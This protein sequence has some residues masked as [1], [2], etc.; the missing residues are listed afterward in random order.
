MKNIVKLNWLLGV[1]LYAIA[2]FAMWS[3]DNSEDGAVPVLDRVSLVPKDSTTEEGFRG[4]TYVIFGNNLATTKAVYFNG[5]LAPL[6]TTYVRNDNIIVRIGDKT[7]YVNAIN[8][9]RVV[10]QYGEAAMDFVVKQKPVIDGFSPAVA[11]A[12][13]IVTIT[14]NCFLGLESVVFVDA[15]TSVETEAEIV[16]STVEEIQV[17]VPEGTKVSYIKVTTPGGTVRSSSTFGFNYVIYADQLNPAW[18]NWSWSSEFNYNST[19]QVKS[20]QYSYKQTYTGGWGGIQLYGA[21]LPL[22][23]G[24]TFLYEALKMSIYGGPGTEGKEIILTINWSVQIRITLAEGK[25]KDFTIPLSDLG[26]P[27]KINVLVMQ[28]VG[29]V[30]VTAPYLMYIDDM[31]LI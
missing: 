8:K 31:G 21:D 6:N 17:K 14:G 26:N 10:T 22:K 28:D 4:N 11:V 15:K 25:W 30:G 29:N 24:D 2:S 16:S 18:Q 19:N 20:G 9:V 13:D 12:G 5:E 23:D 7:P 27:D 3:C 1:A